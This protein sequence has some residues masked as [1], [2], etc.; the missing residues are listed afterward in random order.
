MLPW[1]GSQH[2]EVCMFLHLHWRPTQVFFNRCTFYPAGILW[3]LFF[4]TATSPVSTSTLTDAPEDMLSA[5]QLILH[6]KYLES[7]LHHRPWP[8]SSPLCIS[9]RSRLTCHLLIYGSTTSKA[10][11]GMKMS[12]MLTNGCWFSR[13]AHCSTRL[14]GPR[15]SRQGRS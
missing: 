5:R 11:E 10:Q 6:D 12:G 8:L 13:D 15:F 7:C 4:H 9:H 2:V 3:S 14:C 1:S